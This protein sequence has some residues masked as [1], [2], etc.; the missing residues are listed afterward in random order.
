MGC[1]AKALADDIVSWDAEHS[2]Q[3]YIVVFIR[4]P[5]PPSKQC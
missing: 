5:I 3:H 4:D 2:G 1:A